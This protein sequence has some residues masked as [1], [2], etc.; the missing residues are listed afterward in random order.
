MIKW[1][2]CQRVLYG[3]CML[4]K[5]V[6]TTLAVWLYFCPSKTY[7]ESNI[8]YHHLES[9]LSALGPCPSINALLWH[10]LLCFSICLEVKMRLQVMSDDWTSECHWLQWWTLA[11]SQAMNALACSHS[12][13]LRWPVYWRPLFGSSASCVSPLPCTLSLNSLS[14]SFFPVHCQR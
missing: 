3:I 11:L 4:W 8:F 10:L 14:L 9:P 12:V 1:G 7:L 5:I 6:F 2:P 13:L